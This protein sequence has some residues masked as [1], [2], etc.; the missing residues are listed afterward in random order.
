MAEN[1]FGWVLVAAPAPLGQVDGDAAGG[2][3]GAIGAT[4][5]AVGA[6]DLLRG[7]VVVRLL[8]SFTEA[9]SQQA[10]QVNNS[11]GPARS[12][13]SGDNGGTPANSFLAYWLSPFSLLCMITALAMNRIIIFASARRHRRLPTISNT[14]L[15]L[16][17]LFLLL[18]ASWGLLVA[19]KAYLKNPVVG[20]LL[21][22]SLFDFEP[23]VFARASFFSLGFG[24]D[25]FKE[26]DGLGL[27]PTTAVLRPFHLALCLSQ[28]LETF[29]AVASG[30]RPAVETG[31]TLFEYSLAFQEATPYRFPVPQLLWVA[32]IALANQLDIHLLGLFNLQSYRL[33]PSTAIGLATLGYYVRCMLA[34]DLVRMPFIIV[35]GYFPHVCILAVIVLSYLIYLA[36]ALARGSFEDLTMTS[37]LSSLALTN[38]SLADDFYTALILYGEFIVNV[39]IHQSYVEEVAAVALPRDTFLASGYANPV[40][41]HPGLHTAAHR[42]PNG[43]IRTKVNMLAMVVH[44]ALVLLRVRVMGLRGQTLTVPAGPNLVSSPQYILNTE[45]GDDESPDWVEDNEIGESEQEDDDYDESI[46]DMADSTEQIPS[47]DTREGVSS[48]VNSTQPPPPR[49]PLTH[50]EVDGAAAFH[51]LLLPSDFPQA[52]ANPVLHYH[53]AHMDTPPSALTRSHFSRYY[54]DERQL[55][56]I[57]AERRVPSAVEPPL[58]VC[59]ICHVNSRQVILWPCKCLAVCESCRVALSLREFR[60]CVCCRKKVEAFSKVYVP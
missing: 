37:L 36:T 57:I 12:G 26:Q 28:V 7:N 10:E 47:E 14:C 54:N 23:T 16:F 40:G 34:G 11:G 38:V 44:K 18:R 21:Q 17:A 60:S 56:D 48:T 42:K 35:V 6:G 49:D 31:I 8:N 25:Y 43:S 58:G 27:G 1:G 15:R 55:R 24:D 50:V 22:S 52:L 3:G 4:G 33:I 2:I 13:D 59:V 51:E 19:C 30:S 9:I 32:L 39:S 46:E 20:W 45:F 29:I 5:A 53:L 41:D